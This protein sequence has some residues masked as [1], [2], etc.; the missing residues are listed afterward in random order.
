MPSDAA[1]RTVT[2]SSS[3]TSIAPVSA[4][5]LVTAVSSGSAFICATANGGGC[6]AFCMVSVHPVGVRDIQSLQTHIFPNPSTGPMN[7][8]LGQ[9]GTYSVEIISNTGCV[10]FR[11]DFQG[12]SLEFDLSSFQKGIYF[13]TVRSRDKV[14]TEKIIKL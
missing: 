14:R 12:N 11:R 1:D 3:D 6:K 4:D 5:G 9:T 2:W 7:L 13:I 8:F 10:L